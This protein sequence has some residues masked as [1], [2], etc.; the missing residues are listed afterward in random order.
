MCL[1]R[2]PRRAC[3]SSTKSVVDGT[4]VVVYRKCAANGEAG[5]LW[6][7]RGLPCR[8]ARWIAKVASLGSILGAIKVAM[9]VLRMISFKASKN[10]CQR[11]DTISSPGLF[12]CT[13]IPSR[14]ISSAEFSTEYIPPVSGCSTIPT[15][16]RKPQPNLVPWVLKSKAVSSKSLS[17]NALIWLWPDDKSSAMAS[18]LEVLPRFINKAPST[19]CDN[20]RVR[21][22]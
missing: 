17:W 10:L 13:S 20:S 8:E 11:M 6:Q 15:E 1:K 3:F 16:L 14:I 12:W 21:V 2:Q 7:F 22:V 19:L 5:T 9:E 4:V 18:I